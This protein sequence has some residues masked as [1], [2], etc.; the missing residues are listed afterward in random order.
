MDRFLQEKELKM[1][2]RKF[3][4]LQKDY[5]NLAHLYKQA[6]ALRNF[7]EK[8]K[9]TQMQ[10]NLLLR[11]RAEA[12]A[13]VKSTFLANMSHE[14]RTPLNAIVGMSRI[15]KT[16][17]GIERMSY[18]FAK[19]EEASNHL[20]GVVNDI[21]DISKIDSGKF[22]LSREKFNLEKTLQKVVHVVGLRSDEK[23]QKLSVAIDNTIPGTLYG[24]DQRLTQV[25]TNLLSNAVKFT[26]E[27][28]SIC[29]STQLLRREDNL[30]TIQID[31]TDSGIGISPQ[32]QNKL[33]LLFN[34][35]RVIRH[36]NLA[37]RGL[38]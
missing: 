13:K 31:I 27:S 9:E 32:Q 23:K 7:T 35:P 21:L 37:E 8:E 30:C 16:A 5:D 29:L 36:V 22:E 26:P 17:K 38:D 24:D 25:I 2:K 6:V 3:A 1:L 15:G 14:I 4:R 12:A 33:L 11:E 19:I 18:C 28:G 10:N 20:L 34:K